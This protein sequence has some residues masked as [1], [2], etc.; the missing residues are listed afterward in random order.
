MPV[1]Y[2]ATTISIYLVPLN[3]ENLLDNKRDAYNQA[4]LGLSPNSSDDESTFNT[5]RGPHY[6]DFVSNGF[7][8]RTDNSGINGTNS[9]IYMAFAENPLVGT[10]NIPTTAR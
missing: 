6:M 7:K 4:S 9:F 1:S 8:I 10:N 5:N 3:E 2:L